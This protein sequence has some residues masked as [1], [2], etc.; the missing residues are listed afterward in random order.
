MVLFKIQL[1][2]KVNTMHNLVSAFEFSYEYVLETDKRKGITV[3][4]TRINIDS[5]ILHTFKNNIY[6]SNKTM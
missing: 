4:N 5:Q 3:H 2:Y 6:K 1:N